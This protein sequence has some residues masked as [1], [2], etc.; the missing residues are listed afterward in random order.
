M[1][2]SMITTD[3]LKNTHTHNSAGEDDE[4]FSLINIKGCKLYRNGISRRE[5]SIS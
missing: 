4:V 3:D 1:I 5:D 2:L